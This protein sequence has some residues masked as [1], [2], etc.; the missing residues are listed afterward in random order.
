VEHQLLGKESGFGGRDSKI[1]WLGSIP[2]LECKRRAEEESRAAQN[3][4][5]A[6]ANKAAG[7]V[8][9]VGTEKQIL[10]G[11]SIRRQTLVSFTTTLDRIKQA[12]EPSL[13]VEWSMKATIGWL[14]DQS[15]A[16][17]WI[18]TI[19]TLK[20]REVTDPVFTILNARQPNAS[21]AEILRHVM[22]ESPHCT[23]EVATAL[24]LGEQFRARVAALAAALAS[25]AAAAEEKAAR[26][27]RMA[28]AA[29]LCPPWLKGRR[30]NRKVYSGRRIFLDNEERRLSDADLD[31]LSKFY[32][33][34]Q[35]KA[36]TPHMLLQQCK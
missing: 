36:I 35:G 23:E 29:A 11:E 32:S 27:K 4:E 3:R 18:D 13:V 24:G 1:E 25:E 17:W 31:E 15:D 28:E 5:A 8:P 12:P 10:W 7:M 33:V 16:K 22:L 2:C 14:C 21:E 6:E 34:R 19:G 20:G 26:E 30:W 9:L